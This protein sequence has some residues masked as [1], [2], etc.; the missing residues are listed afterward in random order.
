MRPP[1]VR[2]QTAPATVR[3]VPVERLMRAGPPVVDPEERLAAAAARMRVAWIAALP[4]VEAGRLVGLITERDLLLAV[5]DGLST[6]V[7]TVR[8]YMRPVPCVIGPEAGSAEA[9][10]RMV[11]L[12]VRYLVVVREGEVVGLLSAA[13]VLHEWGVPKELLGDEHL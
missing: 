6:D 5:A 12:R 9:A 7:V 2:V 8:N 4:V 3:P 13:D 1:E 11:E 10:A